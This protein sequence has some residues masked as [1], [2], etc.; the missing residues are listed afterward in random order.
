MNEDRYLYL[1]SIAQGQEGYFTIGQAAELGYSKQNINYHVKTG[2]WLHV[3][4]G[5]Y[6]LPWFPDN[7]Q[8][9]LMRA[10]LWSRDRQ[11]R[12]QGVFC[13]QSAL[14][15][16]ELRPDLPEVLELTVPPGFRKPAVAGVTVFK[17]NLPADQHEPLGRFSVTRPERTFADLGRRFRESAE[18]RRRLGL[19]VAREKISLARAQAWGWRP[20]KVSPAPLAGAELATIP[21]L[22]VPLP[23]Y[24]TSAAVIE[25]VV[26]KMER[27]SVMS[28]ESERSAR[29]RAQAGFTLV[30]LLVVMAII[31]VLAAMLL[32]VL[33][34]SLHSVRQTACAGNQRQI[35][36]A[37]Q[38]YAGDYGDYF[39]VYRAATAG[40]AGF[41][42][43]KFHDWWVAHTMIYTGECTTADA[44][45]SWGSATNTVGLWDCAENPG[46]MTNDGLTGNYAYNQELSWNFVAQDGR[47]LGRPS[48][49]NQ[50]AQIVV[51]T[52]G[53]MYNLATAPTRSYGIIRAG[54]DGRWNA[55][56]WHHG[57]YNATF[58]DG[59]VAHGFLEGGLNLPGVWFP[60]W[61][62]W[63]HQ[64]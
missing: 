27:I 20:E 8:A 7:P 17:E 31:S 48:G 23:A 57:G 51:T 41:P 62:I 37:M 25:P 56:V 53:G 13:R 32:P 50:P 60:Q 26:F 19:A 55:G 18:G 59:H 47:T 21:P 54:Y 2:T 11:D 36:Q 5:L 33:E 49:W 63:N 35:N 43:V 3:E 42:G 24:A 1:K 9:K 64:W 14:F 61:R 12:P 38:L 30:E 15:L 58:L 29:R 39:P 22:E 52:D 40:A 34:N 44:R 46:I 6:R 4:H 16:H 10:W 28:P 45:R